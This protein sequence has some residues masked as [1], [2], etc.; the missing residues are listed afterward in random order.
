MCNSS[1]RLKGID[2]MTTKATRGDSRPIRGREKYEELSQQEG[3]CEDDTS[4]PI[5]RDD[6]RDAVTL[7]HVDINLHV[8]SLEAETSII[9]SSPGEDQTC[10]L[11]GSSPT[12]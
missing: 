2:S 4:W 5:V 8:Q 6:D 9:V 1:S 12:T 11:R 3:D 7:E 10:S